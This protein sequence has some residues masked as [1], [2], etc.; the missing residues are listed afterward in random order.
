MALMVPGKMSRREI[1][2]AT[3]EAVVEGLRLY[4]P[5]ALGFFFFSFVA[6]VAVAALH[7]ALGVPLLIG[8]PGVALGLTSSAVAQIARNHFLRQDRSQQ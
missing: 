4:G 2:K 3:T 6:V 7:F 1:G 5:H 8:I